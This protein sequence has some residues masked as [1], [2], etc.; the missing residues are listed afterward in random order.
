MKDVPFR[1]LARALN[2]R[3]LGGI[4]TSAGSLQRGRVYR[5]AALAELTDAQSA[6]IRA[7]DIRS[8]LDLRYNEERRVHP[9]PWQELGC[10]SFW[11]RDCQATR[12]HVVDD[13]IRMNRTAED[14]H[15][16]MIRGYRELPYIH[17]EALRTLFLTLKAGGGSVLFHCTSGKDRTGIAAALVLCALGASHETIYADYLASADF[18]ILASPA[19]KPYAPEQ[20]KSLRPIYS[21][22]SDYLDAMFAA[23]VA[24][25]GSIESYFRKTLELTDSDLDQI[26][27]N[28]LE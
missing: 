13:L 18:D 23:I 10:Q 8:I 14:A 21:V 27:K 3:D 28:I 16:S 15:A 25:D 11:D 17:V 12:G 22:S 19:F 6:A 26:G 20:L 9:T 2:L 24:Q 7:L 5:S 1:E 4:A